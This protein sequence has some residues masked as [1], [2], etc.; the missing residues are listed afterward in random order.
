MSHR[1][2]AEKGV[3]LHTPASF[4]AQH[5][6]EHVCDRVDV[7]RNIKSPPEQVIAC[8]E[9]DGNLF[10][11]HG[12]NQA[13]HALRA[14]GAA[15]E[16][17]DHAALRA[18]PSSPAV[19]RNLLDSSSDF[20]IANWTNSGYTGRRWHKVKPLASVRSRSCSKCGH[21]FSGLI[22]SGVTGDTP[23]Q[24]LMPASIKSS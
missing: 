15:A 4:S 10:G 3:A 23:P 13:V 9:D 8:V 7:G 18:S 6:R 21:G 20:P 1:L 12:L 24:S 14:P 19:V 22:K 17:A 2:Q 16:H 5:P 11:G